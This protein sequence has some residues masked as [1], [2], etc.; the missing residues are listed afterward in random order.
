MMWLARLKPLAA[1]AAAVILVT[2]G[3]AVQGRQG[4]APERVREQAK[5]APHPTAAAVPYIAASQALAR[6]QLAIIDKALALLHNLA[7]NGRVGISDA[8]FSVWGR[9]KL[10]TIRK[11]GAGKTEIV[12]ALEEYINTLKQEEATAEELA[13]SGRS[14]EVG[15]YDARFRRIEAEIFL[16]EEKAR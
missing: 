13:K 14:T 4:P 8:S 9:R 1:V 15:V 2:A 16:N 3:V 5:T 11:T 12:A 7:Q 10:E 6:E